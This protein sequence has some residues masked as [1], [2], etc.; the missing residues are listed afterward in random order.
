[1]TVLS[2]P[3]RIELASEPHPVDRFYID[4]PMPESELRK[5]LPEPEAAIGAQ[6]PGGML[7]LESPRNPH[8]GCFVLSRAQLYHWTQQAHWQ[9][10]DSSWVSPFGKCCHLGYCQNFSNV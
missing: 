5:I 1:M 10:L 7:C 6:W 9:D 4:G 2:F 8:S 3:H